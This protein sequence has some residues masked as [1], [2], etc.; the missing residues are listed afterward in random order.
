MN[1][2]Q[3]I[4]YRKKTETTRKKNVKPIIVPRNVEL[5]ELLQRIGDN[6]SIYVLGLLKE[7]YSETTFDN[8]SN[9]TRGLL[10]KQLKEI[11]G[12][13]NLSSPLRLSKARE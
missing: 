6:N 12:K 8:K 5:N 4:F 11:T 1:N 7:G 9:K 2:E 13:L 3:I 10:N